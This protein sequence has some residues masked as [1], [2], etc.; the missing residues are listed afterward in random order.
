MPT[1][2][3]LFLS[4]FF[5]EGGGEKPLNYYLNALTYEQVA[6]GI[7]TKGACSLPTYTYVIE[8]TINTHSF[9]EVNLNVCMTITHFL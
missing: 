3:E 7:K 2:I 9:H 1:I 5:F 8:T 4:L 6:V